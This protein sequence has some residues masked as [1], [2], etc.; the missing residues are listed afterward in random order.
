MADQRSGISI[1]GNQAHDVPDTGV[2]I[3]FGGVGYRTLRAAVGTGDRVDAVFTTQGGLLVAG[4]DGTTP[5]ALAVNASGQLEVDIVAQQLTPIFVQA[6][7][8]AAHDGIDSAGPIKIGGRARS[9]L[10][11][12]MSAAD[13]RVDALFDMSGRLVTAPVGLPEMQGRLRT[14]L[15]STTETTIAG[16][17]ASE[18]HDLTHL[19]LSNESGTAVRVDIRDNTGDTVLMSVALAADGGG[20]VQ[21][22]SE[23]FYQALVNDNWTAQ[24]SAVVS[25][26]YITAIWNRRAA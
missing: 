14:T 4:V 15:T 22:F 16:A 1:D 21:Q 2:R 20:A 8:N 17:T 23:P 25:S 10:P 19:V 12:L 9:A 5:I 26:V 7:G 18:F 11:E 13:D 6:V 3:M 24:L